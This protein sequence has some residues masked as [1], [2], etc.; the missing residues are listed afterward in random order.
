MSAL[1]VCNTMD[2]YQVYNGFAIISL[3]KRELVASFF[4]NLTFSKYSF[5]KT[6]KVPNGLDPDQDGCSVLGPNYMQRQKVPLAQQGK[7]YLVEMQS[8]FM[9]KTIHCGCFV[10][11]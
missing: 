2:T 6:I 11:K 3:R 8:E 7:G 9:L 1:S 4:S 5:K 10:E